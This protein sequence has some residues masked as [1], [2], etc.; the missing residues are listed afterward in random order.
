MASMHAPP[1]CLSPH[2]A[3]TGVQAPHC[4]IAVE[5]PGLFGLSGPADAVEWAF[6]FVAIWWAVF[7]CRMVQASQADGFVALI[8]ADP[9]LAAY[10]G[11][12]ALLRYQ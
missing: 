2:V 5:R 1:V 9:R 12:E 3:G 4:V 8:A 10:E 11:V 6:V 7:R